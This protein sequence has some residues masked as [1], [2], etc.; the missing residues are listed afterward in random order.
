MH[1]AYPSLAV[2]NHFKPL[3][4]LKHEALAELVK[5]LKMTLFI[6]KNKKLMYR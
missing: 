6:N 2:A 1:A 4:S 5:E 3:L